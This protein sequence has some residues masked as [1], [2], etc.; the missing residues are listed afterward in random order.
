[1]SVCTASLWGSSEIVSSCCGSA[2]VWN[3]E[4][5]LH[6][7]AAAFRADDWHNKATRCCGDMHDCLAL[8]SLL[9]PNRSAQAVIWLRTSPGGLR[10]MCEMLV[11][12]SPLTINRMPW[13]MPKENTQKPAPLPQKTHRELLWTLGNHEEKSRLC[14]AHKSLSVFSPAEQQLI[15]LGLPRNDSGVSEMSVLKMPKQD[16]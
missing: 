6:T 9:P 8:T 13:R 16:N 14:C 7:A 3:I 1:M 12:K 10:S 11:K 5:M 4:T 15:K 2:R